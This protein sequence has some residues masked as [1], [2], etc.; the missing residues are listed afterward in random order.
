MVDEKLSEEL[1]KERLLSVEDVMNCI[2]PNQETLDLVSR[3]KE[4]VVSRRALV[5]QV[6][7]GNWIIE[8]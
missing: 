2:E 5:R 4:L 6:K 1:M 7:G 8:K 3:L